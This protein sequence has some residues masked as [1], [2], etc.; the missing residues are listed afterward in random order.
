MSPRVRILTAMEYLTNESSDERSYLT[1][2]EL[3]EIDTLLRLRGISL[4]DI[5]AR[6]PTQLFEPATGQDT[7]GGT[8][9][10][11]MHSYKPG[12]LLVLEAQGKCRLSD[13]TRRAEEERLAAYLRKVNGLRNRKRYTRK[14]GTVHPK[15]KEATARRNRERMWI[16]QPL[17]CILYRDRRKC[18]RIDK[19]LWEQ[20]IMKIW[21]SHD[22]RDLTIDFPPR[23]GTKANP[24]TLWNMNITHTNGQVLWKGEDMEIWKNAGGFGSLTMAHGSGSGAVQEST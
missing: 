11:G 9:S 13:W 1:D 6:A 5:E 19:D 12:A 20:E 18:K 7:I 21:R 8:A 4:D 14:R 22:P 23:A 2:A 16:T 10:L 17:L 3:D 15:K 24:W